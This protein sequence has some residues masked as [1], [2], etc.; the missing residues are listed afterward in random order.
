M[1]NNTQ[2]PVVVTGVASGIGAATGRLLD[3]GGVPLVGVDRSV[4]D[5]FPGT[6]VRADLSS[7]AG[8]REA[9]RAVLASAPD[10]LAG[11]A[12]IAGVPGTAPWRTVLGV[13]VF[14]LRELT[15]ALAPA[16]RE[17]GCVVNLSSAVASGWRERL[18]E[19]REFALAGDPEAALDAVASEAE[20]TGNAYRF[21]KEC[22][23]Y[24]TEHLAAEYLP[25]RVRVVSVSPGPVA[26]PILDDFKRDHGVAK[27]EG[28]GALLGRFGA[29]EDIARVV[30]FLLGDSAEWVNGTDLRVD[31]GLTAHRTVAEASGAA[32]G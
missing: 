31:G 32:R 11:L 17:G 19:V 8:V 7:P 24:L 13:N 25:R 5:S 26:T 18:A 4:P 2:M 23:R 16:V 20:V 28:A 1:T 6:F 9:A 21:S 12:N 15:R 29:P 30:A 27:V 3:A 10:G 14:G 22:V